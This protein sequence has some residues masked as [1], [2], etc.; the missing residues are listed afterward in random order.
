MLRKEDTIRTQII[1]AAIVSMLSPS[2]KPQSVYARTPMNRSIPWLY[3]S[4]L[5]VCEFACRD[6]GVVP[7]QPP[8]I[9]LFSTSPASVREGDTLH[10]FIR[11]SDD[12]GL[13]RASLDCRD[14]TILV[15]R[16]SGHADSVTLSHVYNT[17]G[18]FEPHL[19]VKD[20]SGAIA[21]AKQRLLVG[22]DPLPLISPP[23]RG[24]EGEVSRVARN[25]LAYDPEGDS[26]TIT[27]APVSPDLNFQFNP[28]GDSVRYSLADP[29]ANGL[30]QGRVT[31]VDH[32]NRTEE[33]IV[34]IFFESRDDISGHVFDRLE[35]TYLASFKSVVVMRPPYS[36][37]VEAVTSGTAIR[38]SVNGDG[39]YTLPKIPSGNHSVRAFITNGADS[40]FVASIS[41]TAGDRICDIGVETNAGTGMPLERLLALYQIA[42]FRS[43]DGMGQPGWLTGINLRWDAGVYKVYLVGKDTSTTWLNTKHITPEQQDWLAKQIDERW[44]PHI[45][46]ALRPAIIKGGP[47]DPLPIKR[48]D[49]ANVSPLTGYLIIYANL[50]PQGNDGRLGFWDERH[51]GVYTSGSLALNGG[52]LVSPPYGFSLT[53]LLR[54][55]GGCISGVGQPLDPYYASRTIRSPLSTLDSPTIADMKLDWQVILAAPRYNNYVEEQFFGLP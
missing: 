33:K 23:L 39:S 45:P 10:F 38:T 16:L 28:G 27:V 29:N 1:C 12:I 7:P 9:A 49:P 36:G 53:T 31:V 30:R 55:L 19:T 13:E 54:G 48:F 50:I 37:W 52:D 34:D 43:R 41:V 44:Y 20:V 51:D 4:L 21:E 14:G 26:V 15:V 22:F 5:V 6:F 35:G 24:A 8:A 46:P 3:I 40:S 11:A 42:N 2:V 47:S 17:G 25:A 32:K 18:I